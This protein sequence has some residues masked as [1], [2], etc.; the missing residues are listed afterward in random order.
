MRPGNSR[1]RIRGKESAKTPSVGRRIIGRPSLGPA[2]VTSTLTSRR[3]ERAERSFRRFSSRNCVYFAAIPEVAETENSKCRKS[4]DSEIQ[5]TV[6]LGHPRMRRSCYSFCITQDCRQFKNLKRRYELNIRR[7]K[8]LCPK[9]QKFTN[10]IIF[11]NIKIR[12]SEIPK[13]KLRNTNIQ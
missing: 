8:N 5:G 6:Q 13:K 1:R 9:V 10:R 7:S 3:T 4:D 12:E 2:F 11:Q